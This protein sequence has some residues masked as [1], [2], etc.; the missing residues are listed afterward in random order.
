M[1][2]SF[3]KLL[4]PQLPHAQDSLPREAGHAFYLIL[5]LDAARTRLAVSIGQGEVDTVPHESL[6]YFDLGTLR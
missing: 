5:F 1:K 2:P 3:P 6:Q 4:H